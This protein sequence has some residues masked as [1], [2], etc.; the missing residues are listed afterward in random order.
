MIDIQKTIELAALKK[1]APSAALVAKD[2]EQDIGVE[3][4]ARLGEAQPADAQK[5][6]PEDD[7]DADD[8]GE[9]PP[10]R[11]KPESRQRRSNPPRGCR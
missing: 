3:A 9:Q 8:E 11:R 5:E 7:D 2:L 10:R 6:E 4:R 1:K